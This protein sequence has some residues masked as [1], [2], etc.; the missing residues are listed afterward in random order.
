[1]LEI[2]IQ[3]GLLLAGILFS[4]GL[5]G[6]L[7]RRDIIFVLM[8]LEVMLNAAGLA[9]VVAFGVYTRKLGNPLLFFL[10][11]IMMPLA[12]TEIGTDGWIEGI[13]KGVAQDPESAFNFHP[14]LV[15]DG[16]RQIPPQDLGGVV[17]QRFDDPH[18]DVDG[19]EDE[20]LLEAVLDPEGLGDD[21]VLG[22]DD[23]VDRGADEQL[24]DDVGQ[25]VGDAR[26]DGGDDRRA[27]TAGVAPQADERGGVEVGPGGHRLVILRMRLADPM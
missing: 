11:L 21:R 5:I 20:E 4:L 2:P 12:T 1:M 7:V 25:L 24:G 16:L 10:A 26:G 6:L 22:A 8:S 3:H 23:D 18:A 15:L 17:G 19:G 9:F 27:V 14:G 13:L